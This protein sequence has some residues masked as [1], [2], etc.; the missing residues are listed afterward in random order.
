[1]SPPNACATSSKSGN[2]QCISRRSSKTSNGGF[3]MTAPA[4]MWKKSKFVQWLLVLGCGPA[5]VLPILPQDSAQAVESTSPR[6]PNIRQVAIMPVYWQGRFPESH[7]FAQS[8]QHIEG[9]FSKIVRNSKRF[10]FSNDVLTADLWSTAEGRQQLAEE[11][12]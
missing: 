11:Y 2:G 4:T 6:L 10:V 9:H 5:L 7:R 8:K 12:E 1:S 3:L